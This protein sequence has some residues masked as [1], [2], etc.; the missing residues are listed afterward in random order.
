VAALGCAQSGPRTPR[1][2]YSATELRHEIL[3]RAPRQ[4]AS[5]VIVPF[6][7]ESDAIERARR[8]VLRRSG[9]QQQILALV[10]SLSDPEVFGLRYDWGATGSARQTLERG[11]GNCLSLASVLIGLARG[12]G[13]TALYVEAVP[14]DLEQYVETDVT[15]WADHMVVLLMTPDARAYV[16]FSGQPDRRYR[17]KAIDDLAATAHFY[18]NRAYGRI[19]R[20]ADDASPVPWDRAMRDFEIATRIRPEFARAWNNLGVALTRLGR[21]E[22]AR[23]AYDT[24]IAIDGDLASPRQNLTLL[25]GRTDATP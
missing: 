1:F 4:P 3:L 13:W 22:R 9:G 10:D 15:V 18:N 2:E 25:Q 6:E 12:L 7:V 16:D 14:A 17:L 11:A 20:A 24:A 5:D 19:H 23:H 21:L 8:V